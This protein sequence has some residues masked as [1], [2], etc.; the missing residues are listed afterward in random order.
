MK[1]KRTKLREMSKQLSIRYRGNNLKQDLATNIL[2]HLVI[3]KL[4]IFPDLT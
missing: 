4:I 1:L 3:P 2:K